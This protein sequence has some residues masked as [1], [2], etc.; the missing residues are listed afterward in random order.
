MDQQ[1]GSI[2]KRSIVDA[3]K[4]APNDLSFEGPPIVKSPLK[5]D[6]Q[7]RLAVANEGK[8]VDTRSAFP[9][10]SVAERLKL[11]TIRDAERQRLRRG[12][13]RDSRRQDQR[14]RRES[15]QERF[16]AFG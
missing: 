7:A 13:A 9:D 11:K 5:Q 10:L 2:L 12:G 4:G 6:L 14:A 15:A 16:E 1:G 8:I 3:S